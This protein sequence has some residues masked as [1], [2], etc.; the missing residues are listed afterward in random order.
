MGTFDRMHTLRAVVEEGSFAAAARR[1]GISRSVVSKHI[2]QLET[3]LGTHLFQRSTRRVTPTEEGLAFYQRSVSILDD[4]TEAMSLVAEMNATPTGT[5]RINAPMSF[6][7]LHLAGAVADFASR[8]PDVR[9]ELVLNDRRID[10]LAEGFDI[11]LRIARPE[12]LT[13]LVVHEICRLPLVLCASPGYLKHNGRLESIDEFSKHRCLHYGYQDSGSVWRLRGPEG[14]I[15][16]SVY[17]TMWS[18]NG[19]VL[20]QAALKGLGIAMLP[21]FIVGD[22]LQA[23]TL[24]RVLPGY[25]PQ[26]LTLSALYPRHRHLSAKVQ[27]MVAFMQEKFGDESTWAPWTSARN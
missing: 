26:A 3:E 5:L 18:N 2:R 23:G 24:V 13:S 19:E 21:S 16:Q 7:T 10:P 25:Q 4:V 1:L 6:G 12:S 27:K 20:R 9:V 22:A 17:C 15:S 14:E 11:T 8:Y